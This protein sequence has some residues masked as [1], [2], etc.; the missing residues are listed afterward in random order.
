MAIP[1]A[2]DRRIDEARARLAADLHELQDRVTQLRELVSPAHY[3]KSPWIKVGA[4]VALGY[5]VGRRSP[6][7]LLPSGD[8]PAPKTKPTT[9][10]L[11]A[12]LRAAVTAVVGRA[13]E[14]A[15]AR[16]TEPDP[17]DGRA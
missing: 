1:P 2:I 14:R 4:G 8:A 5:L 3:L 12:A 16:A 10:I 6:R 15:F 11:G 9:G 7:R 13:I 17:P